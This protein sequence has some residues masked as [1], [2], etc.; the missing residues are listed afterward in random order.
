MDAAAPYSEV[1]SDMKLRLAAR[2]IEVSRELKDF[3]ERRAHFGLGRFARRIKSL[4]VRLT[5]L[6]GPRG[7]VDQRCD[8]R[9]D[10]GL[11]QDVIVSERRA[12]IHAA[13]TVATERAA[14]ALGRRLELAE[15][16]R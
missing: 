8:I 9:V 1:M 7:G 11:G 12:S 3:I 10:A 15:V 13:V 2:G 16:R 14:R 6:N 5:D 4:T